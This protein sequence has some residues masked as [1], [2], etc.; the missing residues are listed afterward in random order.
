V[1]SRIGN[2]LRRILLS[3][4][5]G[6]AITSVRM[7]GVLHEFSTLPGVREDVTDVILNIKEIMVKLHSEG[8][9]ILTLKANKP[10][11]VRAQD[12]Q[13]NPNVQILN[14]NLAIATLSKDGELEIEMVVKQGRGYVPAERNREEEQPIGTIPLDALFSSSGP[15]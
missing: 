15:R 10:G 7:K 8:P 4:L 14:P 6:A 13:A 9:E 1:F 3:S 5:Q 2:S 11:I 12:I